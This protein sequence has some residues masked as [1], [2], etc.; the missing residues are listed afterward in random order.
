MTYSLIG[1]E[2][3]I[4]WVDEPVIRSTTRDGTANV[5]RGTFDSLCR[6]STTALGGLL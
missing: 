1:L 2:A 4:G 6:C 3:T 5:L